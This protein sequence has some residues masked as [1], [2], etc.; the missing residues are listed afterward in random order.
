[1]VFSVRFRRF[2][3]MFFCVFG[4]RMR[5]DRMMRGLF[6]F[7]MFVVFGRFP[8]MFGGFL[9][10]FGGGGMMLGDFLGVRH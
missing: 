1:V 4:M 9:V 8:M 7:A 10:M 2:V 6:M 5:D 3:V